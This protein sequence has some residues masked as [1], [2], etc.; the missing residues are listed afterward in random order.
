VYL[1]PLENLDQSKI[2]QMKQSV[3]ERSYE[4]ISAYCRKCPESGISK[5]VLT[6]LTGNI[7]ECF[8]AECVRAWNMGRPYAR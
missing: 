5:E 1:I 7:P 3:R 6:R 4:T 2:E 8:T